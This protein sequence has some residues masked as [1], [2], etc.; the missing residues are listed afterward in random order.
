MFPGSPVGSDITLGYGGKEGPGL[1]V[2]KDDEPAV[3]GP[4]HADGLWPGEK[5]KL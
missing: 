3:M 5:S 2:G 1:W 4:V